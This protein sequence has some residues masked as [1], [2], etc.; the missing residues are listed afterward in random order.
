MHI[1]LKLACLNNTQVQFISFRSRLIHRFTGGGLYVFHIARRFFQG[2]FTVCHIGLFRFLSVGNCRRC[3]RNDFFRRTGNLQIFQFI[4]R[5][6]GF[7]RQRY[8]LFHKPLCIFQSFPG[9]KKPCLLDD[10]LHLR[11]KL[12]PIEIL[13]LFRIIAG[14]ILIISPPLPIRIRQCT[15]L[16]TV[17]IVN[18]RF[19][20]VPNHIFYGTVARFT[21]LLRHIPGFHH[22]F[23]VFLCDRYVIFMELLQYF[24]RISSASRNLRQRLRIQVVRIARNIT[25]ALYQSSLNLIHD[26][27]YRLY[28]RI[29]G[30]I[31]FFLQF[32]KILVGHHI[33]HHY[34]VVLLCGHICLPCFLHHFFYRLTLLLIGIVIQCRTG[35]IQCK[36]SFGTGLGCRCRPLCMRLYS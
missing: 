33:G 7:C 24:F 1:Q 20:M 29:S 27:N 35:N 22:L 36:H 23:H 2:T 31:A 16:R 28:I 3:G 9:N 25:A 15:V 6:Y 17:Y 13:R 14:G 32:G 10:F 34:H 21:E 4:K 12:L 26:G 5:I 18:G 11:L 30:M 19:H 8:A